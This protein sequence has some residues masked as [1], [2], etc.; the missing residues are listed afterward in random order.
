MKSDALI[1]Y[2]PPFNLL[3]FAILWPASWVLSPRSLH[4]AN[5]FLI[6]VTVGFYLLVF[7]LAF[8]AL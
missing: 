2:Q 3:A 8:D 1:S 6:R 7:M 5:V 4:S